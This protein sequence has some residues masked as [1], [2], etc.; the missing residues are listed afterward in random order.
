VPQTASQSRGVMRRSLCD[1][2]LGTPP[3]PRK[4]PPKASWI[5]PG[6]WGKVE[7]GWLTQPLLKCD[8]EVEQRRHNSPVPL[9]AFARRRLR[10]AGTAAARNDEKP[11]RAE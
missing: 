2:K 6:D 11:F 5:I 4:A 7:P 9:A 10:E 8:R 1:R 3:L